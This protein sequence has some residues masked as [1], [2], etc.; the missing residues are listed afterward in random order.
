MTFARTRVWLAVLAFALT[1]TAAFAQSA[2]S[3]IVGVV[4]DAAGGQV[5]G[6]TVTV[7]NE[8]TGVSLT[9]V[10]GADGGFTVPAVS[11]GTYTV[12][13]ALQ[14]FKTAVLKDV[15]V[16]VGGPANVRAKLEVGGVTESIT[17]EGAGVMIQ[18]QA[19][20]A[21][22]TLNT[23][24]ILNLPVG[25]RNT[26]DFVQFL[27]G[28]QTT[29]GVRD[30][31]VAG[32][33][34]SSINITVD[35]VNVQDNHLKTGDGFFA[36]MSPRLDAVEQVTLTTGAQGADA[37]GQGATQINFTTRS[38]TN[39]YQA[40]L[41]Y[42]AQS[43]ALNTNTYSN[44]VR[45][46]P[47][48]PLTLTQPGGRI[49]GPIVIPG[50]YDGRNKAFFFFNYEH[51]Y[52]PST[53]TS[54]GTLMVPGTE[55]GVF[56]YAGGPAGGIN[57]LQLAASNGFVG[58]ADPVVA[59]LLADIRASTNNAVGV[60]SEITGSL[61]T[62]RFTFQQAVESNNKFPTMKFDYNITSNHRVSFS[63]NRNYILATPDTTN[64]RQAT[65][66]GFPISGEQHS[67]RYQIT[68]TLRSTLS[69]NMVNE[70]RV[71]GSG[72]PTE[73]SPS[74][75]AAMWSGSVAN[76][77]GYQLGINAFSGLTTAGNG[78][79]VS[80]REP[81]TRI[82]EDTLTWLKGRHSLSS[83]F[84]FL[85]QG[86]WVTD[87]NAVPSINMDVLNGDP[88]RAIFD[89]ANNFPGSNGTDR[90]NA[91][92][93]Y[94]VLTG[95]VSAINAT[96]RLDGTTGQYVY[97]GKNFQEGRM[98]QLDL[99]MQD[100]WRV[101]PTLTLNMGLRYTL[102]QPFVALN[103]SYSVGTVNDIWGVS[104]YAPGCGFKDPMA[105]CT[106]FKP[107][108]MNG[109]LPVYSN[110]TAK[111][112]IFNNDYDNIAPSVGVNWSPNL[113]GVPL[114]GSL[115]GAQAQSSFSAGFSRAFERRGSSDF[116]GTLDNNPGLNL[117][118]NRT[119]GNANLGP[120]PLYL[121][122][123][124]LGP[125]PLCS[126]VNNA[127]G[128]MLDAPTYP[129]SNTNN[130]GAIVMFDPELQ[131]P[132]SDTYTAAWQRQL[133]SRM[134]FEVRYLGTRSRD[135]WE[136]LNYNEAN[137]IE[138]NFV[139][140][141]ANAQA[142]LQSHIAAGCGTT[143]Q[144]AC[145]FA[146]RGP[147]TGTVPLPIYLAFFSGVPQ[148]QAGEVARYNSASWSNSNFINPLSPY[149]ANIFTPAGT[150][151]NTG[152]GGDPTRAANAIA[153][154]LPANFF[155]ANPNMLGGAQA[156]TN[157]GF[158]RYN[159]IQLQLNR[160]LSSGLQWD[161]NYAFGNGLV[162]ERY[163]FRVPRVY[164]RNE[165]DVTHALK[166]SWVWEIPYGRGK[167]FGANSNTWVDGIAGGWIFS[168]T[169]R[170][171]SGDLI[172]FGNVRIVGMSE[173][174]AREAFGLRKVNSEIVY[175]WPQ[176]IIDET[177]KAYGTSATSPTGYGALGPP[178]GRY[179]A[180]PSTPGC[181]ETININYGDCGVQSFVVTGPIE[182]MM[183]W[184][185]RKNIDLP[186][187]AIF[188][189]SVD[190]FNVLNYVQW[191]A[192]TTLNSTTLANYQSGLPNSSRRMQIG[193]RYTW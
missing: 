192:D 72:G 191:S 143:G 22:T 164:L 79:G 1:S 108:T 39:Q 146:Y 136:T 9:A 67:V 38:G 173:K 87:S 14:G 115:F 153:A 7:K 43:D 18:T 184:S 163:S 31:T 17:V 69:S 140:E 180:P 88:V 10:S 183:D 109:S 16:S 132:F 179:F 154:G 82:F 116:T 148:S 90:G 121:R 159:S 124:N 46:L 95:S 45:G 133:G 145:S 114:F 130:T 80:M 84:A 2:T 96:A 120:L 113:S 71:G 63:Q 142:N 98:D 28:V 68:T 91:R 35:G 147:G 161:V 34:Q 134:R 83:G 175:S 174:E 89:D 129:L 70:L 112:K 73:F 4:Q 104:G 138:T 20:Q 33:P 125:P 65:W 150:N 85:R 37:T 27:P 144:A 93:L 99:F 66:P 26:L 193:L 189:L 127:Q 152:L 64:T 55:T 23:N 50:V 151:A 160:R 118:A 156:T 32:L 105:A 62:E 40:S 49:G 29:G 47:K 6:A 12:S 5:P 122:N 186:G 167:R 44:K 3:S 170:V 61:N 158:T 111:S 30:S 165:S 188:Q 155:R 110:L 86:I 190:I 36:R 97:N 59:R 139:Q 77:M 15:V 25:S 157:G 81:T 119:Q 123:G 19:S 103:N 117:T 57:V 128:C 94:A 74:I 102:Q 75:N 54:N 8:A 24:Q 13:V 21:S 92:N 162:D 176:D 177:I 48:G 168:G 41:Y 126:T 185:M 78:T 107:G 131:L 51:L 52:Q 60:F 171:Q 56:R 58:S 76:Q 42:F 101:K 169:T 100:N 106:I 166:G 135:Q 182:V 141:F 53:I 187:R 137:I 181:F 149:N 172:D 178:S 11:V